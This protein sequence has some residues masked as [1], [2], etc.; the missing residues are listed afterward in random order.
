[1]TI[2]IPVLGDQ[3]THGLVSMRDV[4]PA[5]AVVLMME[6]A[7]ETTYVK[8]HPKKIALIFSAMRHFAAELRS[9]GWTVDYVT[10]DAEG[11]TG[12]F[13]GEVER[14]LTRHAVTAIR[15]VE[16][17]E[18]RVQA[19]LE[20]WAKR[21]AL[22]VEILPDDRFI[23]SIAAFKDWAKGRKTLTME[24]FYRDLRR[25]TGL[26]MDG[27]V[28]AGGKWNYDAANRKTPPRGLNYPA[29][30]RVEPDEVTREVLALVAARF[31]RHFGELEPFGFP[32]TRAQ[33]K[34]ALKHFIAN[35]LPGFGDYQDAML[36]EQ[37]TL[38]HAV[39]SPLLNCGLLTPLEVCRAA[40]RAYRQGDVPLNAVEGFVRQ[41]LGWREYI[42]GMYWLEM[43]AFAEAN[44][45]GAIRPLPDFYW[46]GDTDM[47]CLAIAVKDTSANAYA[48]HIQRLMVL[49]NFALLAG[50]HP[51]AIDDWFLVVYADAYQWVELPNVIG[52][53]QYADGGRLGS[54][55]YVSSG[56]YIDRMSDYC[57]RCRYDVKAK[58]GADACPFN[59]L[60]WDFLARHEARF[61]ANAR[62]RNQY[63][64]WDRFPPEYQDE[65]RASASAFLA[66]LKPAA[67]GWA[68][69]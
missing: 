45:L 9:K 34:A 56:A 17:G 69:D 15:V 35:A 20:G 48:H 8:H 28:P 32:V 4:D 26:L 37:D 50:V 40:E 38:Y 67:Q 13:S 58:T 64:S 24:Y 55:P 3:L 46:T 41:I 51:S 60:Y 14:A 42:R 22:S 57:G 19:M 36:A 18:W 43:P 30:F 61:R 16:A 2:L 65:L 27:D 62:M 63:R 44:A 68:R 23:S 31:A 29:P 54:K 33:A 6:V 5:D 21:F 10:L 66:T 25:A 7:D 49:G 1:M 52:M 12:S 47:R 39:L 53:S 11:N 59:A